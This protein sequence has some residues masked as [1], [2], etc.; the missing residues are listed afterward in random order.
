M[1]IA[2]RLKQFAESIGTKSE[3]ARKLDMSPQQLNAYISGRS[4][5]GADII[6]KLKE[7]GCDTDWLLTG[8]R[9]EASV[10][11]HQPAAKT[12]ERL[13][14]AVDR[15][16]AGKPT[17]LANQAGVPPS[18][19]TRWLNGETTPNLNKLRELERAGINSGWLINGTGEALIAEQKGYEQ[20]TLD[21]AELYQLSKRFVQVPMVEAA[22][23][24]GV[25]AANSGEVSMVPLEAELVAGVPEP[26]YLLCKG[27]SMSPVIHDGDYVI[28]ETLKDDTSKLQN[29]D[30]VIAYL[31]GEFT[32]KYFYRQNGFVMLVPENVRAAAPYVTEK[33]D[34]LK[35]IG[36]VRRI[37]KNVQ[38]K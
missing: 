22:F 31:N 29:G 20:I 1:S 7:I 36:I 12:I 37:L 34:E 10:K 24:C 28:A 13:Q 3:L 26:Y 35:I 21:K 16:F 27:D 17:R 4:K 9:S 14:Y 15:Y 38:D 19:I 33:L 6:I 23:P 5:P 2:E 8:E 30:I 18:L 32:V 11:Q 25:P